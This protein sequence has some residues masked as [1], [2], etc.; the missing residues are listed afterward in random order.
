MDGRTTQKAANAIYYADLE[1]ATL[2][3]KNQSTLQAR[4]NLL[5]AEKNAEINNAYETGR[6]I[7]EINAFYAAKRDQIKRE[8]TKAMISSTVDLLGAIASLW[9][10]NT[11][12][13]KVF[14][15]AQAVMNTW[16]GVTNALANTKGGIVAQIAGVS[17]ALLTGF[18]AVKKIWAVKVDSPNQSTGGSLNTATQSQSLPPDLTSQMAQPVGGIINPSTSSAI[19]SGAATSISTG[20]ADPLRIIQNMPAPIVTV[21]DIEVAQKRVKVIDSISKV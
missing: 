15:T 10:E 2:E 12:E 16:L 18:A 19:T 17:T 21:K 1:L 3:A 8:E 11:A 5:D 9:G 13:Y 7:D 4:L 6:S 20:A 14:A